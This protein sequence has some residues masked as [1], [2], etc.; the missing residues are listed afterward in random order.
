MIEAYWSLISLARLD[1]LFEQ[2]A[3]AEAAGDDGQV[4]PEAAPFVVEA[5]AGETL[6]LAEQVAAAVEVAIRQPFLDHRLPTR[7]RST[8]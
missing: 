3:G 5:M 7:P 4:G 8:S 1:D 6:G 2:V